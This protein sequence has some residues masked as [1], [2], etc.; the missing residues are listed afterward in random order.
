MLYR[1]WRIRWWGSVNDHWGDRG[2]SFWQLQTMFRRR[3][4]SWQVIQPCSQILNPI[5]NWRPKPIY[6]FF[7]ATSS[8]ED[9]NDLPCCN[10]KE[11]RRLA[12][13]TDCGQKPY[14]NR[15]IGGV[16]SKVSEALEFLNINI[17]NVVHQ[18]T[19][20]PMA[21]CSSK[22]RRILSWLWSCTSQVS[23]WIFSFWTFFLC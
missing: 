11:K 16:V 10:R 21:L 22:E 23:F 17:L 5:D 2:R 18:G 6:R 7:W 20:I 19:W 8:V 3:G 14:H 4:W 12:N 1:D 13:A 9:M 15:I